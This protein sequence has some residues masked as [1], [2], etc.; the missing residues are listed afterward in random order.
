MFED[1]DV[2]LNMYLLFISSM[3]LW[4]WFNF[5]VL[6][7][8]YVWFRINEIIEWKIFDNCKVLY[9]YKEEY[10]FYFNFII[11]VRKDIYIYVLK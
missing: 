11:V 4:K 1:L 9:K 2:K 7:I 5:G 10:I 3:I 6:S 8:L